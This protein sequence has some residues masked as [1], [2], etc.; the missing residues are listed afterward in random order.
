MDES[1]D[2]EVASYLRPS[3]SLPVAMANSQGTALHLVGNGS[4]A[5][6][7]IRFAPHKGVAMHTHPG[8]HILFVVSGRG[9]LTCGEDTFFLVPGVCYYVPSDVPHALSATDVELTLVSVANDHRPID[10][11]ERLEIYARG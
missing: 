3:G 8:A 7:L 10:S 5:A 11:P 2:L 4:F 9:L 1:F 6:D